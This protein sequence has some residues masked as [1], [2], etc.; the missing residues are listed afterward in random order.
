MREC[1]RC[2]ETKPETAFQGNRQVCRVCRN[3]QQVDR[4]WSRRN[5][6]RADACNQVVSTFSR[7]GNNAQATLKTTGLHGI[8]DLVTACKIDLEQWQIKQSQIRVTTGLQGDQTT[9]TAQLEAKQLSPVSF[10]AVSPVRVELPKTTGLHRVS[11]PKG[12]LK[13]CLVVP[14]S[15]NGFTRKQDGTLA[16]IHDPKCW[17]LVHQ[18]NRHIQ[19]KTIVLLGDMLDFCELGRYPHTPDHQYTLQATLDDFA[20]TLGQL[21]VDNPNAQIVYLE[22]NHEARFQKAIIDN[23]KSAYGLKRANTVSNESVFSVPYLL[24]L[25]ELN[26]DYRASYPDGSFWLNEK[27]EF[28]HGDI[29]RQGGGETAKAVLKDANHSVCYGHIHRFEHKCYTVH[30]RSGVSEV[31]H[32]FSP[33]TIARI[34]GAVPAQ[35]KRNDWQQGLAVVDYTDSDF[36][37]DMLPINGYSVM[38]RGSVFEV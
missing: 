26:I 6:K 18:L 23:L 3:K 32:A 7:Q 1:K 38:Y 35:S 36:W 19:P 16:P 14:D 15:Q 27:L 20:V 8:D 13:Q 21:R 34:D 37:V 5:K 22:G 28:I 17:E 12:N 4:R 29:V 33:G 11:A 24:G 2:G 10:P 31:R 9:I 25:E 30:K